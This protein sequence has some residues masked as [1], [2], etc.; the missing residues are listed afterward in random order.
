MVSPVKSAAL[1]RRPP[2]IVLKMFKKQPIFAASHLLELL[3]LL[4]GIYFNFFYD[5]F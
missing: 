1:P 4:R 3:K 5:T 2:V